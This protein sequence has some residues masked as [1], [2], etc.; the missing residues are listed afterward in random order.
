MSDAIKSKILF[1]KNDKT[2]NREIARI[3]GYNEAAVR[4]FLK[5][6]EEIGDIG[7]K[8]GSGRKSKLSDRDDRIIKRAAIKDRFASAKN[9]R[10]E[11]QTSSL[12]QVSTRTVQRRL[13][14]LGL[15]ALKPAKKPLLTIK[16]KQKRLQWARER[17]TWTEQDWEKV[18]FSDESK[19]N[20]FGSDGKTTV[21]RRKGERYAEQCILPTVKHS[22]SVMV[23]GAITFN[24]VGPIVFLEGTMNAAKYKSILETH[25]LPLIQEMENYVE[26][27]LFQDDSAPCHRAKSVSLIKILLLII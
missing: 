11:L 27:P 1:L 23:W 17:S 13:N 24:K 14:K 26:N 4:R 8:K 22:P 21:R 3:V 15:R 19:F 20:L 9:I 5:K 25:V 16:M 7:R 18:V 2:S 10:D 12:K 6:Y